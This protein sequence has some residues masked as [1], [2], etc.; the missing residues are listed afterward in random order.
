MSLITPDFGLLFWM[1]VIFGIVFF[2]LAKF[3][4]PVITKAVQTRS[5]HIADS[6]KA[7]DEAQARLAGLAEEQAR[8]IEETRLEQSRL[9][10]EASESRERIIAQAKEEAAAE[11]AKLLDHAKVEIAAERE[12]AIRDIRRQVAMISVEVAEKIVRK[13]LEGDAGQQGLIDRMVD[14]AAQAQIPN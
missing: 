9:L 4:F 12:S 1:V 11:A 7:A 10:K 2:L 8:M 14:E 5:D 3:G 13:D 6:L